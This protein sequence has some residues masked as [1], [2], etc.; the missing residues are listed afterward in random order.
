MR[1]R[2]RDRERVRDRERARA[3]EREGERERERGGGGWGDSQ[4]CSVF[5]RRIKPSTLSSFR[6]LSRSLL[7]SFGAGGFEESGS[8]VFLH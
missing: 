1:D 7:Q 8:R 2:E 6:I 3:R 5:N 4:K